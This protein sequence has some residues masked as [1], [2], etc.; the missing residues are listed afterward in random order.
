MTNVRQSAPETAIPGT[1]H[2]SPAPKGGYSLSLKYSKFTGIMLS[3][4][5]MPFLTRVFERWLQR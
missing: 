1:A 2:P 4:V 3:W 5:A